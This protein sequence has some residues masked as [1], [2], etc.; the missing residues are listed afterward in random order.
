[1]NCDLTDVASD[2][3]SLQIALNKAS[4]S[5]LPAF[6]VADVKNS[7]STFL[8]SKALAGEK[9]SFDESEI[10]NLKIIVDKSENILEK[11]NGDFE[12]RGLGFDSARKVSEPFV[13]V[14]D[15]AVSLQKSAMNCVKMTPPLEFSFI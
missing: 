12:L 4:A 2:V 14:R 5:D 11:I 6:L 15:A 10:T 3:H 8:S 13:A 1:M 9:L 7:L